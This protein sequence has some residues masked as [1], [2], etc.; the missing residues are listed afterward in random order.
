[1]KGLTTSIVQHCC[2]YHPGPLVPVPRGEAQSRPARPHPAHRQVR[3]VLV[4][5]GGYE[6]DRRLLFRALL[7]S[8][9]SGRSL[10]SEASTLFGPEKEQVS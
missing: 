8:S 10:L 1:M 2:A 5:T 7:Q 3:G 6:K 9:L 4:S